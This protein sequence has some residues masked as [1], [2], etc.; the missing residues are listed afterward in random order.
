M[1]PHVITRS[2]IQQVLFHDLLSLLIFYYSVWSVISAHDL[3]PLN[4]DD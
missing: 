2:P 3:T 1:L 4:R